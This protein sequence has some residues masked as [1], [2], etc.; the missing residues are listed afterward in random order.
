MYT[1]LSAVAALV[2]VAAFVASGTASAGQANAA[3]SSRLRATP[4]AMARHIISL[5]YRAYGAPRSATCH[6]K[7]KRKHGTYPAFRC[8]ATGAVGDGS[9][10]SWTVWAKPLRGG[11]CGSAFSLKTCH[12]LIAPVYG[13]EDKCNGNGNVCSGSSD[14]SVALLRISPQ[15]GRSPYCTPSGTNTY[16]CE[17]PSGTWT[18]AWREASYGWLPTV[19]LILAVR[20]ALLPDGTGIGSQRRVMSIP[21][22]RYAPS[23]PALSPNRAGEPQIRRATCQNE[24]LPM[25]PLV[26]AQPCD[27]ASRTRTGDLLGAI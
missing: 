22:T 15:P 23:S 25:E 14:T 17:N 19:T 26:L 3:S 1:K 16:T 20:D 11:W 6:G 4:A 10:R 24:R 12:R 5:G 21:I 8:V 2:V 18:V 9:P 27:G 13:S 7:G